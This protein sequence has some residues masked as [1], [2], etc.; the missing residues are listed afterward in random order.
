MF[1]PEFTGWRGVLYSQ[2]GEIK[3]D[4]ITQVSGM[5]AIG[6][7]KQTF[8]FRGDTL[9]IERNGNSFGK[10]IYIKRKIPIELLKNNAGW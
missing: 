9:L 3:G 5:G 8:E 2:N 10:R 4:L 1:D 6:I 7:L